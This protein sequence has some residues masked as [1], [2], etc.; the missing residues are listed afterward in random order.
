MIVLAA[1]VGAILLAAVV[2]S[3]VGRGGDPS[4][5]GEPRLDDAAMLTTADI[6]RYVPGVGE[7]SPAADVS[8][9][10]LTAG[11]GTTA[12][13]GGWCGDSP[14]V[15]VDEPAQAW[16]AEWLQE[17]AGGPGPEGG[18]REVVLRWPGPE[19][20]DAYARAV[21]TTP[22]ECRDPR[23]APYPSTSYVAQ[24]PDGSPRLETPLPPTSLGVAALTNGAASAESAETA[25]GAEYGHPSAEIGVDRRLPAWRVRAVRADGDTVV[26]LTVV[27]RSTSASGAAAEAYELLGEALERTRTD[28][29]VS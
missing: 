17:G 2:A 8:P 25:A 3:L 29:Q 12:V 26:D 27:L 5:T 13:F 11:P 14:L 24:P 15:G 10:G 28:E 23:G 20:A 4:A 6:G 16:A 18:A 1:V 7:S 19:G 22:M 21:R 9:I